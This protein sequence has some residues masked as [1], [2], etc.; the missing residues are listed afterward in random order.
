MH[1]Q[2]NAANKQQQ[3]HL[4]GDEVSSHLDVLLRNDP[5]VGRNNGVQPGRGG[6]GVNGKM[7]SFIF[8][9]FIYSNRLTEIQYVN[10]LRR[11]SKTNGKGQLYNN[12]SNHS[13]FHRV[14]GEVHENLSKPQ[15][16]FPFFFK[17]KQKTTI[18]QN[19][20]KEKTRRKDSTTTEKGRFDKL[21]LISIL[22]PS[23]IFFSVH[24]LEPS[25]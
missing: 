16:F 17:R 22:Y 14:Q 15:P 9:Y 11:K 18:Y 21:P 10:M 6:G 13:M 25:K 5:S 20:Q 24:L 19:M 1:V 2:R 8:I 3:T 7:F 23:K 12:A 4:L